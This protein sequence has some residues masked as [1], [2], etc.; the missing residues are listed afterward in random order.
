MKAENPIYAS[1]RRDEDKRYEG[2]VEVMGRKFRSRK[3][4]PNIKMAEQVAALAALIGLNIRHLL[5]GEW[6]EL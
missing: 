3:G 5:V 2:S 6:E 4:Q 1:H